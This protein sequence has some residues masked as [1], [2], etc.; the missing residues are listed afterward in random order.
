MQSY[1]RHYFKSLIMALQ[2]PKQVE[3]DGEVY[4]KK[5]GE[6]AESVDLMGGW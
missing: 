3:A 5:Q 2:I 6:L 4:A 1:Y